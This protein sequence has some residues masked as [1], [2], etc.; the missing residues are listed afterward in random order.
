M[1]QTVKT[2]IF[3]ILMMKRL[4]WRSIKRFLR[5]IKGSHLF[6][7]NPSWLQQRNS[8]QATDNLCI[9][10]FIMVYFSD[11]RKESVLTSIEE[12][13]ESDFEELDEDRDYFPT[14]SPSLSS[15]HGPPSPSSQ[16]SVLH[17]PNQT[18]SS[19]PHFPNQTMSRNSLSPIGR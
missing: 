17:F 14:N 1:T 12:D 9:F 13:K 4:I 15:S 16:S 8:D 18:K 6:L 11:K 2:I 3:S 5:N 10:C 19:V 7:V